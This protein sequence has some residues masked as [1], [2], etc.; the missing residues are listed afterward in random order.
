[1]AKKAELAEARRATAVIII[2]EGSDH[3]GERICTTIF[4]KNDYCTNLIRHSHRIW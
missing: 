4:S 2:E 3:K 1:V